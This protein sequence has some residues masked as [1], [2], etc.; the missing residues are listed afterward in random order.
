MSAQTSPLDCVVSEPA[1]EA[2]PTSDSG[3]SPRKTW[4]RGFR[5][6]TAALSSALNWLFGCAALLVG[7]AVLSVIP[8]LNMLSLG[9]LLHVSGRVASAGRLRSAWVGIRKAAVLGRWVVG[10]WILLL[11]LRFVSGLSYEASLISPASP[12]ARA[13]SMGFWLLAT[14]TLLQLFWGYSHG[15]RLRY[16][17]RPAPLRALRALSAAGAWG[18][19]WNAA[20]GY[21]RSLRLGYYFWLGTRG[22]AGAVAW[23]VLPVALLICAAQL[24]AGKGGG[25]L[26]FLGASLL[27]PVVLY[28]PFLQARFAMENRFAALFELRAVRQLFNRAPIAFWCALLTTLLFA[29]PLYL[30]KIELPPREIAWLPSLLFVLFIFPAR[31]LTG[32]A[33]SR[34]LRQERP[35]HAVFRW[36]SRIGLV[37]IALVY[38]LVVYMTQYLSWNGSLSLLEQHAFLVPAPLLAQ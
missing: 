16:F 5:K 2:E 34:A 24:P 26:S 18:S 32:W 8:L 14:L 20:A 30:L 28:L 27:A 10:T 31:S 22:F 12:V 19:L 6:V 38:V 15:G 25:L 23:L 37:P 35:R 11:P 7:L 13:W 9:Y 33:L 21:V 4:R 3:M 36:T 29:L 1:L 17:L